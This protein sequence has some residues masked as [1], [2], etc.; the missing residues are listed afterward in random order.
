M[1]V[2]R[3]KIYEGF[4]W[5]VLGENFLPTEPIEPIEQFLAYLRST[6]RSPNTVRSYAYH[7]KLYWQFL[8]DSNREWARANLESL[9]DFISWLRKPNPRIVSIRV[10]GK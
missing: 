9:A 1:K 7:L 8:H 10:V 6:E 5:T 3:A 4:T 2:Q